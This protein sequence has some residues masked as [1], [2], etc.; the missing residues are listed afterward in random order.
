MGCARAVRVPSRSAIHS[1]DDVRRVDTV[2]SKTVNL[3]CREKEG[4]PGA[5]RE[6]RYPAPYSIVTRPNSERKA[7]ASNDAIL[8]W[9]WRNVKQFAGGPVGG[10]WSRHYFM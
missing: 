10:H 6:K 3:R 9:R 7:A 1:S 4:E 8:R 2:A 5:A